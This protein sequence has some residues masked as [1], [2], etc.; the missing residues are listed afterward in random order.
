[1]LGFWPVL[2]S[3]NR[4]VRLLTCERFWLHEDALV[5]D[6]LAVGKQKREGVGPEPQRAGLPLALVE[7]GD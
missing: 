2:P 4:Y 7:E 5:Q 3:G 6:P 1:M